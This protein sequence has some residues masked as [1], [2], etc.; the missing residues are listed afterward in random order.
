MSGTKVKLV[1]LVTAVCL[2]GD[3]M[4]YV[5]LPIYPEQFGLSSLWEVGVLLAV[6]RF[7]RI[8]IHPFVKKFYE[9]FPTR[10]G[11]LVGLMLTIVSTL[12]YGILDTFL[13]LL[14]ARILW[15]I[16]WAFLRQGGQLSVVEAV[17]ESDQQSGKLTGLYNGISRTGSLAGMLMGGIG[18]GLLGA[19]TL[20][21][22]FA[23]AAVVLVPFLVR[24]MRNDLST[25]ENAESLGAL[26]VQEMRKYRTFL[27]LLM[28]GFL[29]ALIYQGLLKSTLGYW[30]AIQDNLTTVLLGGLGAAVWTGILQG[31]RWGLEPIVAPW[32]GSVADRFGSKL[33]LLLPTLLLASLLFILL[34]AP[35]P[36]VIWLF[37][38]VLLLSTA[39]IVSTLLDAFI[40]DYAEGS[41]KHSVIAHYLMVSDLGAALGPAAGFLLIEMEGP[42]LVS[43]GGA[44][45]LLLTAMLAGWEYWN[46]SKSKR[47]FHRDQFIQPYG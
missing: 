29:V 36:T 42:S 21:F 44:I 19:D 16:A 12:L 37:A 18:T 34:P 25:F 14:S 39:A 5:V 47:K 30:V 13:W 17:R 1:A 2:L 8:P 38:V 6:N 3:S 28:T 24:Y 33:I 22:V 35:I 45:I 9:C 43:W 32:I 7:V 23:G 20:C 27:I 46:D 15:G 26:T 31:L 41:A 40:I 10:E 11:M 4:L